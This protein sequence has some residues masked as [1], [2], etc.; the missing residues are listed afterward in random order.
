MSYLRQF[1]SNDTMIG[2][3]IYVSIGQSLLQLFSPTPILHTC[4]S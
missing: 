1:F 2:Y 3:V 4:F